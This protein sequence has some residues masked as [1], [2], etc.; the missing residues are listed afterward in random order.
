MIWG[1][2]HLETGTSRFNK[3]LEVRKSLVYLKKRKKASVPGDDVGEKGRG[4]PM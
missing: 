4:Q 1:K 2:S 3:E